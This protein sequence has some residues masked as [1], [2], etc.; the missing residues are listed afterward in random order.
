MFNILN[1]IE[2]FQKTAL[3]F[4]YFPTVSTFSPNAS[5]KCKKIKKSLRKNT[6][7]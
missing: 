7:E 6:T 4:V 2:K 5:G 3:F 1:L